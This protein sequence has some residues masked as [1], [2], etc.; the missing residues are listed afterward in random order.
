MLLMVCWL[1]L[2]I[3]TSIIYNVKFIYFGSKFH[4]HILDMNLI[5]QVDDVNLKNLRYQ[6]HQL[7]CCP[8]NI[9]TD[10]HLILNQIRFSMS[11]INYMTTCI[12]ELHY[13]WI[14]TFYSLCSCILL[15]FINFEDIEIVV[16]ID[17]LRCGRNRHFITEIVVI[18]ITSFRKTKG[19][20]SFSST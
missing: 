4:F 9:F 10:Q 18:R 3:S 8:S 16:V 13:S 11:V 19:L 15:N 6:K 20:I 5:K 14:P 2:P 17:W 1:P 12:K 7:F